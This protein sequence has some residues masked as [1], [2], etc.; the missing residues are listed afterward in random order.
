MH[1]RTQLNSF[2]KL[3]MRSR[4]GRLEQEETAASFEAIYT[5]VEEINVNAHKIVD[6]TTN[7]DA[8]IQQTTIGVDQISSVVQN[9][10]ATA[11]ESAAASEE[12]SSQAQMLK[13]MVEKFQLPGGLGIYSV[14]IPAHEET[15]AMQDVLHSNFDKY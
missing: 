9:N 14:D 2:K 5:G 10:S 12:L 1:Q 13:D 7:Q 11:E 3:W 4:K 15:P 8:V 6:N